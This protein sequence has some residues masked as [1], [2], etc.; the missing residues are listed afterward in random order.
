MLVASD[1]IVVTGDDEGE[2]KVSMPEL[3][4]LDYVPVCIIATILSV[5]VCGRRLCRCGI[6]GARRP[7]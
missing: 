5:H 6:C 2:I 7:S 4:Y 1:N 3:S